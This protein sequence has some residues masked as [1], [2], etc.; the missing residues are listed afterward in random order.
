LQFSITS[1]AAGEVIARVFLYDLPARKPSRPVTPEHEYVN[2][3]QFS[4]IVGDVNMRE[5]DP[6][7]QYQGGM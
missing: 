2:E 5:V 6:R 4:H 3:W 7:F 1:D